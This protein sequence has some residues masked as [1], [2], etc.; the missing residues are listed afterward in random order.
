MDDMNAARRDDAGGARTLRE[1]LTRLSGRNLRAPAVVFAVGLASTLIAGLAYDRIAAERDAQRFQSLVAQRVISIDERMSL[2]VGLL[3]GVA[4]HF[5][6][7]DS[8]GRQNFA[9][10]VR[11][12]RIEE[13]Y[14]GIQGVGYAAR[15]ADAA[16]EAALEAE[17]R[18][19]GDAGFA[20]WPDAAEREVQDDLRTAIV[21]LQPEDTRNRQAIGFD[22]ASEA[23]RHAAMLRARDRGRSTASGRVTL[24]QETSEDVQPGFLIYLPVYQDGRIPE[25]VE[26]R[27][28]Q[29]EGWVYAPFRAGDLF[30]RALSQGRGGE[31]G[32]S[33]YDGETARPETLLYS[34]SDAGEPG[35]L[36]FRTAER[37]SIA[38]RTW[39]VVLKTT[40]LFERAS[41]RVFTPF[42][43]IVGLAATGLL[44]AASVRQARAVDAAEQ[45]RAEVEELNHTLE[46]RVERRTAQLERARSR[47]AELNVNL[48]RA[49]QARTAELTAANEEI[50]RFA[51]IVSHDLRAPLVNVMGFTAELEAV[52]GDVEAFLAE[53]AE[54]AP[55][56]ASDD[57]RRAIETD[58][59]E[60]LGF[61]RASTQKMDR[62]I[63]AILKLSRE[64][65]R[66][67]V[68]EPVE[69]TGLVETLRESVAHQLVERGAPIEIGP[70]PRVLAARLGPEQVRGH[71][72]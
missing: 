27:R 11:R 68:A 28:R 31:V 21:L 48:E 22:M 61:I 13:E 70:L 8:V 10:L 18:A 40:P 5:A 15:I 47:L 57:A 12:M 4:A 3:R 60:A 72:R 16:A 45:A 6:A 50:Q 55:Q 66:V 23:T 59:P 2:Y 46:H 14:P 63:N 69:L 35:R 43:F 38:D 39:T 53:V 49:V 51:Y 29:L 58:L 17:L 65:R 25:T 54:A 1:R 71:V 37:I 32:F 33:V 56:I 52:R 19:Q 24:I 67:L 36:G 20:V 9:A 64:G 42:I 34:T 30:H 62:L 41:P 26:E 7:E 44:T